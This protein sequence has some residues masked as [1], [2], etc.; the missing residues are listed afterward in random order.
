MNNRSITHEYSQ[1]QL[2]TSFEHCLIKNINI[3]NSKL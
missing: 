1:S 3:K 2:G